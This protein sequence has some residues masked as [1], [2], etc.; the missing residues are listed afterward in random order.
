MSIILVMIEVVK[1]FSEEL[2]MSLIW[3][4]IESLWW[5]VSCPE[6]DVKHVP[7]HPVGDVTVRRQS[8]Q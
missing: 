8:G 6:E 1:F 5:L 7:P 3:A 2:A 4:M